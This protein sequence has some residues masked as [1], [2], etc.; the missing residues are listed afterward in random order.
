MPDT[1]LAVYFLWFKPRKAEQQCSALALFTVISQARDK[2]ESCSALILDCL[3]ADTSQSNVTMSVVK[4]HFRRFNGLT[5]DP[6]LSN[7]SPKTSAHYGQDN[8]Q[9]SD[10]HTA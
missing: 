6:F 8:A 1:S 2:L 9:T 10:S 4:I 7:G 5:P 3:G